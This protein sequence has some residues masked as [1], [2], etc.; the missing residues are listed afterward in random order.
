M[1]DAGIFLCARP[2]GDIHPARITGEGLYANDTRYLSELRVELGGKSPV[3]LSYAAETGYRA[4][5]NA[6][7]ALLP[8]D[9][10]RSVPQQTL[11]VRRV[12]AV[13][14]RLFHQLELANFAGRAVATTLELWLAADFA[15]VFEVRGADQRSARGHALAPKLTSKGLLLAYVGEDEQ[16]RETVV[17][18]DPKPEAIAFDGQRAHVSWPVALGPGEST[19]IL[20]TAEP[21]LGGKR[22][23]RRRLDTTLTRLQCAQREWEAECTAV[24]TDNE[25]F[26]K[27]VAASLRDLHA[28]MTP[29]PGGEIVAAGIPWYVAPFGRDSLLTAQQT[30]MLNPRI[31]RN[32]LLALARLQAR[33]E[34]PWRDAEPG[35][36]LHE[37]RSGELAGAGIIPHTPYYGSVDST[38]L[39]IVLAAAYHRWTGDTET[40]AGLRPALDAALEWIDRYGDRDGDGFVEYEVRSSGGLRNQGWK[41]SGDSVMH[42]DGTLAEGPIALVEVQGYVYLAKQRIAEV[43]DALGAP[44]LAA[45]LRDQADELRSTFNEAF[46][47]AEEGT[48]VLALD[49]RKRQVRS[50]TSNPGHCLYCGIVSPERAAVLA[51]RLM[52]PD[53]FS[54]WGIRTLSSL[55]PAYNPMSYHNGSVWPHDNALIAAGLK[56]YGFHEATEKIASALFDVAAGARDFRLPELYCGFDRLEGGAPVAYPVACIPQAWA[57]ATPFMLLQAMLGIS[58]RSGEETLAVNK[59]ILPAWLKR[60]EVRD[61]RVASSQVS[62]AFERDGKVTGFSLLEQSGPVRVN[63]AL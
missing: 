53:M 16:F 59:P 52:A 17:E 13:G 60:S 29:L 28:L 51:E 43:Y 62:L 42:A 22:R 1:K 7:N 54:G 55:S 40:L 14:S 38:P 21:S 49:G 37:L 10:A 57:A 4:V 15:D 34:D 35:K 27:F 41:D 25:L 47:D 20:V 26:D 61:L 6:T 44:D 30:L 24:E 50:V 32:T 56:R 23:A 2:D 12:I 36:I 63:M 3:L 8:L 9:E 5:V 18:F 19:S 46:W 33:S 48:F 45:T 58:A 11:G 31:A 39:F